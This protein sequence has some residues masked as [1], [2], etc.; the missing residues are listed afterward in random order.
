MPKLIGIGGFTEWMTKRNPTQRKLWVAVD[1]FEESA[2]TFWINGIPEYE[3]LAKKIVQIASEISELQGEKWSKEQEKADIIALKQRLSDTFVEFAKTVLQATG[4]WIEIVRL[5]DPTL[6]SSTTEA[7]IQLLLNNKDFIVSLEN[8][9]K[10]LDDTLMAS[11]KT[12]VDALK[13]TEFSTLFSYLE[14]LQAGLKT[15]EPKLAQIESDIE[16]LTANIRDKNNAKSEKEL[17]KSKLDRLYMKMKKLE[18]KGNTSTAISRIV[19]MAAGAVLATGIAFGSWVMKQ[20]SPSAPATSK[21]ISGAANTQNSV[22]VPWHVI[23]NNNGILS[24]VPSNQWSSEASDGSKFQFATTTRT[25]N[26]KLS[27]GQWVDNVPLGFS[28]NSGD[29]DI[30]GKKYKV[31]FSANRIDV[32]PE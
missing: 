7:D 3:S 9:A 17:T 13:I 25:M 27:S 23:T 4:K 22:I 30:G 18:A 6:P 26:Y 12:K 20:D 14:Q 2:R 31:T 28:G 8:Q 24:I 29:I 19:N 1:A 32:I 15:E 10:S 21:A 5:I 11:L 16:K